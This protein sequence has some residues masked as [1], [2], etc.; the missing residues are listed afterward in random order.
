M[1]I[2]RNASAISAGA[3]A[4]ALG[5]GLPLMAAQ[6]AYADCTGNG[7]VSS[8]T[9]GLCSILGGVGKTVDGL[10]DTVDDVTGGTTDKLTGGVDDVVGA[11]T[12]GVGGAVDEVGGAVDDTVDSTLDAVDGA[13]GTVTD[14]LKGGSG[15]QPPP[16]VGP[17][18]LPSPCLPLVGGEGCGEDE[19]ATPPAGSPGGVRPTPKP[20]AR[21]P[22][23][24]LPVDPSRPVQLPRLTPV[25]GHAI[26]ATPPINP[27]M[28]G[29][30]P[31]LWPGQDIPG[32]VGAVKRDPAVRP[33][34]PYD[35]AGTALTAALLLSAVLATRVVSARRAR[36][37][38]RNS[39]PLEGGVPTAR[40][41]GRHRLA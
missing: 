38:Q 1:G 21:T 20:P 10:T 14:G 27:D 8:V 2:A 30:I 17:V 11:V 3:L 12:G 40:T 5:G 24:T 34:R 26:A 39:I 35:A 19:P 23:G 28:S 18:P 32:L 31:M 7:L 15:G 16:S 41:S 37:E 4:I 36:S 13:V 25:G 22:A 6:P 33:A 9:G 29:D